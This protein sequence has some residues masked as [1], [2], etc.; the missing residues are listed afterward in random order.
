MRRRAAMVAAVMLLAGC[1]GG[2]GG[3]GT[4]PAPDGAEL[5]RANCIACHGTDGS[6]GT[7]T[8]LTDPAVTG[9]TDAR[10]AS[11]IRNGIETMPGFPGLS[12]A[13]ISA[14]VDHVRTL[15]K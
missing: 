4:A 2:S 9:L 6:G 5:Y 12:D 15:G 1:G 8:P 7:G 14:L 11:S 10:M 13:E 3:G